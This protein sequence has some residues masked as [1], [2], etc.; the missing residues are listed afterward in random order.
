MPHTNGNIEDTDGLVDIT[1][2]YDMGWQKRGHVFNSSTGHG[3]VMSLN[4]G[5]VLGFAH[6]YNK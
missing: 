4:S 5:K 1:C 2:S 6:R 3:A